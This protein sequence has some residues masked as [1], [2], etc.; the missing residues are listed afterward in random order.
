MQSSTG[1]LSERKTLARALPGQSLAVSLHLVSDNANNAKAGA[2]KLSTRMT[3]ICVLLVRKS[4]RKAFFCE[5][6]R[7]N[8]A[9]LLSRS[10][11]KPQ[12]FAR[13][14]ASL[15]NGEDKSTAFLNREEE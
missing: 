10:E 5:R 6:T 4:A 9:I 3:R 12:F 8:P 7:G 15:L 14:Q 11:I 1:F 2:V 13:V